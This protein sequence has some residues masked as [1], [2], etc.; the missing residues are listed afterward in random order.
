MPRPHQDYIRSGVWGG[1]PAAVGGSAV[2]ENF[3]NNR[4]GRTPNSEHFKAL[5]LNIHV[6]QKF[7]IICAKISRNLMSIEFKRDG[8]LKIRGLWIETPKII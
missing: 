6:S 2:G 4:L 7:F 5:V 1:S 8:L 3:Y